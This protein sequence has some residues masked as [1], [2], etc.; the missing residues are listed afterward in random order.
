[1]AYYDDALPPSGATPI[2]GDELGS[3]DDY[4]P[5]ANGSSRDVTWQWKDGSIHSYPPEGPNWFAPDSWQAY[6]KSKGL[7]ADPATGLVPFESY[8]ND[9]G[10][11][12]DYDDY[13]YRVGARQKGGGGVFSGAGEILKNSA[14]D[15][16]TNFIG[17]SL[18]LYGVVAGA[19]TLAGAAGVG[20]TAAGTA[21]A[22]TA[23]ASAGGFAAADAAGLAQMAADVGLTGAAASTFVAEGGMASLAS[24]V[25]VEGAPAWLTQEWIANTAQGIGGA[26]LSPPDSYWSQTADSGGTVTDAGP[27]N[28][29]TVGQGPAP[30]Q[31]TADVPASN[32]Q[33]LAQQV[34]NGTDVPGPALDEFGNAIDMTGRELAGPRDVFRQTISAAPTG[35]S[36]GGI[37]RNAITEAVD[38]AKQNKELAGGIL[39]T[40]GGLGQA[41]L[42]RSGMERKTEL[43]LA[44]K[45]ALAQYTREFGDA[46]RLRA[47]VGV[48]PGSGAPLRRNDG[49]L[50]YSGGIINRAR[51]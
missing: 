42:N 46:G 50:V 45:E 10:L 36:S 26:T 35:G 28:A 19:G 41:L 9:A 30:T 12:H 29:D 51:N 25:G 20:G 6:A 8:Q 23:G 15:L 49:S 1:M 7:P 24:L 38:W 18:A 5:A 31:T 32:T 43:E 33:N 17:P 37:I 39:N 14:T 2:Y 4:R 11:M 3:G 34:L 40:A 16:F 22:S 44:N 47:G 21:G 13:G 27:V 48:A